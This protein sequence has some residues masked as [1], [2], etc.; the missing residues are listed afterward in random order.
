M[1]ALHYNAAKKQFVA[2]VHY[3]K[4]TKEL[5]EHIPVSDDWVIDTYGKE[6]A[7]KLIDRE[8]HQEF[9]KPVNDDGMLTVVKLDERK[10]IRVKYLPPK[11]MHKYDKTRGDHITDQVYAKGIWRGQLEDGTVMPIP[12]E[13]AG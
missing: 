12:E 6:I 10:I 4:G 2:K 9:L 7:S 5:K 8:E 11:F 13:L 1:K 3:Q